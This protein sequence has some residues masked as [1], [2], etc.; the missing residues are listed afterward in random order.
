MLGN[1]A[2]KD[3]A[4]HRYTIPKGGTGRVPSFRVR[5]GLF[6]AIAGQKTRNLA[7]ALARK[8]VSRGGGKA[9]EWR[10]GP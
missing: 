10:M 7:L 3:G 4:V 9:L 6:R 5:E 2:G 8:P 1:R